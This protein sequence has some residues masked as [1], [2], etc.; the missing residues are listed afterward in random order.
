[1]FGDVEDE[2][3]LGHDGDPGPLVVHLLA[4]VAPIGKHDAHYV[5]CALHRFVRDAT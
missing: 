3:V 1:M 4:E 5:A 2:L